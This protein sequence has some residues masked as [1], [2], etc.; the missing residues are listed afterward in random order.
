MVIRGEKRT[1]KSDEVSTIKARTDHDIVCNGSKAL[2]DFYFIM[3]CVL[4]QA[5]YVIMAV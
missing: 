2:V 1:T 3:F 5:E 4:L